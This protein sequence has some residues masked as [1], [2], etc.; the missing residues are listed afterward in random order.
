MGN[1]R[2]KYPYIRCSE[3]GIFKPD[4]HFQLSGWV[5]FSG[6]WMHA[7]SEGRPGLGQLKYYDRPWERFIINTMV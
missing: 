1:S 5:H 2:E 3:C 6:G 7:C 4:A